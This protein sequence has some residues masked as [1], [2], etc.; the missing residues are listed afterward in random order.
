MHKCKCKCKRKRKKFVTVVKWQCIYRLYLFF[1]QWKSILSLRSH[2]HGPL[3]ECLM[4]TA[5][6]SGNNSGV[7]KLSSDWLNYTGLL[8]DVCVAFF[9]VQPGQKM[10]WRQTPLTKEES[11][12]VYNRWQA[13]VRTPKHDTAQNETWLVALPVSLGHS[14][15]PKFSDQSEGLATRD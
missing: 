13:L 6:L 9:N 2:V 10:P 3:A 12:H 14:K 1:L 7:S 15:R 4:H 8:G 11:R 5:H